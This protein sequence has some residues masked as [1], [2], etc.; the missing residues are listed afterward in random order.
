MATTTSRTDKLWMII[1]DYID[2]E[3][4]H[5]KMWMRNRLVCSTWQRVIRSFTKITIKRLPWQMYAH[6]ECGRVC[7]KECLKPH[8]MTMYANRIAALS[9][10]CDMTITPHVHLDGRLLTN[11]TKLSVLRTWGFNREYLPDFQFLTNLKTLRIVHK[12]GTD[13]CLT[14]LT[15][16][17]ELDLNDNRVITGEA[18]RFLTNLEHLKMSRTTIHCSN[19]KFLTN[20]VSLEAYKTDLNYTNIKSLTNLKSL[21]TRRGV[22]GKC[23][24]IFSGS[25]DNEDLFH[26]VSG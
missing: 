2:P 9:N 16:L 5:G 21:S 10:I 12:Y 23:E 8:A 22:P 24:S 18:F 20:L 26:D 1:F 3:K 6:C 11:L 17:T 25:S 14:H 19:L 15:N 13:E 7:T 4:R